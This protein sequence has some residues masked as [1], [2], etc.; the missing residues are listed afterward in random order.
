[1]L[2][3]IGSIEVVVMFRHGSDVELNSAATGLEAAVS[4]FCV[5]LVDIVED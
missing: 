4:I 3:A 1:M 5:A 2:L